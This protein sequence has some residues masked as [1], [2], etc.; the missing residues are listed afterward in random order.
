MIYDAFP[1]DRGAHTTVSLRR[2]S[3][4]ARKPL[5][6]VRQSPPAALVDRA[7]IARDFG[8]RE[9][10]EQVGQLFTHLVRDCFI[11]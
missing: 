8:L 7:L 10:L 9:L 5:R 2:G 4:A 11:T 1:D 6:V 3:G